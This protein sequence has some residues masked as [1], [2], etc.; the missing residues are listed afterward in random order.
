MLYILLCAFISHMFPFLMEL[1]YVV[2]LML[3]VY[4]VVLGKEC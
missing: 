3:K 1:Y 4:Y 2:K